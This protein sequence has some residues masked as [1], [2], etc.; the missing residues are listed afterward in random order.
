MAFIHSPV[1]HQ[2]RLNNARRLNG[3]DGGWITWVQSLEMTGS[4]AVFSQPVLRGSVNNF[5]ETCQSTLQENPFLTLNLGDKL[6]C[7]S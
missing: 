1:Y 5:Q 3:Y 2:V 6:V 4:V 7:L